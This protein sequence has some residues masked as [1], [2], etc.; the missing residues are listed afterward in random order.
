MLQ[1]KKQ[2]WRKSM[3]KIVLNLFF[4]VSIPAFASTDIVC[5]MGGIDELN[6]NVD[7]VYENTEMSCLS[8]NTEGEKTGHFVT[9]DSL[10][11]TLQTGE[12]NIEIVCTSNDPKGTYVGIKASVGVAARLGAAVYVG[13]KGICVLG[14][15]GL[16]AGASVAGSKLKIE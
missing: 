8:R 13:T 16:G 11:L 6:Q 15:A 14:G 10:G 9:I 12:E 1:S 5:F 7:V 2:T 4:L 3:K